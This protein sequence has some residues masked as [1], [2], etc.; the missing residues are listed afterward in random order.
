[1]DVISDVTWRVKWIPGTLPETTNMNSYFAQSGQTHKCM[2][3]GPIIVAHDF[4][5]A[6][7]KIY[8]TETD[9]NKSYCNIYEVSRAASGSTRVSSNL[10]LPKNLIKESMFKLLMKRKL[11]KVYEASWAN[12]NA[13]CKSLVQEH[14][15]HAYH[16]EFQ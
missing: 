16:I 8:F 15:H 6:K 2:A 3:K 5:T 13:Y 4:E 12:L 14:K 9:T 7:D 10:Y 11:L 1:F